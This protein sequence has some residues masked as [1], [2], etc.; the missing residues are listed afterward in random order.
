MKKAKVD[1]LCEERNPKPIFLKFFSS[2]KI[3]IFFNTTI[4]QEK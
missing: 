1:L 4:N 2:N 3:H